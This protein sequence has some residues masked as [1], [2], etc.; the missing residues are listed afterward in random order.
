[1]EL[2]IGVFLDIRTFPP[3][4]ANNCSPESRFAFRS[5]HNLLLYSKPHFKQ[6]FAEAGGDYN[7]FGTNPEHKQ[8]EKVAYSPGALLDQCRTQHEYIYSPPVCPHVRLACIGESLFLTH[9]RHCQCC[10]H[11]RRRCCLASQPLCARCLCRGFCCGRR[12]NCRACT[13]CFSARRNQRGALDPSHPDR[14]KF[15]F[16]RF[17]PRRRENVFRIAWH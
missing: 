2:H 16:C 8:W 11:L 1:M 10:S 3:F 15:V 9:R 7:V 6:M 14:S 17:R 4:S 5:P 13:L 12:P